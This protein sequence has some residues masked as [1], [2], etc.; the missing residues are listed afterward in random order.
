[1]EQEN[2]CPII[3]LTKPQTVSYIAKTYKQNI[4]TLCGTKNSF[5]W[6]TN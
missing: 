6:L 4:P 1:M 3:E 2:W 5:S